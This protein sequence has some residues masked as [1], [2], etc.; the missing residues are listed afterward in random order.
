MVEVVDVVVNEDPQLAKHEAC[1]LCELT[2]NP[3]PPQT[4]EQDS[5]VLATPHPYEPLPKNSQQHHTALPVVVV[6]VEVGQPA[7][8]VVVNGPCVVVDSPDSHI[9]WAVHCCPFT[10]QLQAWVG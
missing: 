2:S 7:P 1:E 10:V 6:V 4:D 9:V 5:P 8:A 3:P